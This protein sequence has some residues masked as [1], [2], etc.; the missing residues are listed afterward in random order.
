MAT[1]PKDT[2]LGDKTSLD[3]ES[4]RRQLAE[5]QAETAALQAR[6]DERT[7]CQGAPVLT[8]HDC[9]RIVSDGSEVGPY[10]GVQ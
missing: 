3:I 2:L 7:D 6:L 9:D 8:D 10:S 1:S 5:S 4:L